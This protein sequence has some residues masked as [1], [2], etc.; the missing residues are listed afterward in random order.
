MDTLRCYF[1]RKKPRERDHELWDR[2]SVPRCMDYL[3]AMIAQGGVIEACN[4]A[5]LRIRTPLPFGNGVDVDQFEADDHESMVM[6][7]RALV[8]YKEL[9]SQW[10]LGAVE[11]GGATSHA[12]LLRMAGSFGYPLIADEIVALR[13]TLNIQRIGLAAK[14][15]AMMLAC[16]IENPHEI[17]R[18]ICGVWNPGCSMRMDDL[19]VLLE[20][21]LEEHESFSDLLD[22]A[23]T[24]SGDAAAS[25]GA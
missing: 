19:I 11:H 16:G 20:L 5:T 18:G 9:A 6:L 13:Q 15:I 1:T 14:S 21:Y 22:L 23:Q 4:L 24:P 17:T 12:A 8:F 2:R 10:N 7:L 3:F 25:V